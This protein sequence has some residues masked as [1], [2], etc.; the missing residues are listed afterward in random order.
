MIIGTGIDVIESGRLEKELR[1]APW[2]QRDGVF[3]PEICFCSLQ[4][5]PARFFAAHFAAKEAVL[6]ALGTGATSL[7]AFRNV[8]VVHLQDGRKHV[9][10]RGRLRVISTKL[11][12]RRVVLSIANT[13]KTSS[14]FVVLES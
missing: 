12:V 2:L 7:A 10:L 4:K 5:Y 9:C 8:E 1:R 14:A 6:K 3:T 11:G 13:R